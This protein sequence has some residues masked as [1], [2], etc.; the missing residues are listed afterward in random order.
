MGVNA[1][2]WVSNTFNLPAIN[3]LPSE[4]NRCCPAE[5][6]SL[7]GEDTS[8]STET[9]DWDVSP[10]EDSI[11]EGLCG[12]SGPGLML[13]IFPKTICIWSLVRWRGFIL[14]RDLRARVRA[15]TATIARAV[16]A[17][18]LIWLSEGEPDHLNL[19]YDVLTIDTLRTH[20]LA[21]RGP[22]Q[23][24]LDSLHQEVIA[25]AQRSVPQVWFEETLL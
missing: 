18:A 13:H 14:R 22:A 15:V 1:V 2:A 4:L 24:S 7:Y 10:S 9:W 5:R 20:L 11:A 19:Q 6:V 25:E 8:H 23:P 16:G 17:G 12:L 3:A 21:Q